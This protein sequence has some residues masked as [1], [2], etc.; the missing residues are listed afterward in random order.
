MLEQLKVWPQYALPQHG[1]S[2]FMGLLAES[3]S[4]PIRKA[5]IQF[6]LTRY[7][8]DL[9]EAEHTDADA[10]PTFNAFFTRALKPNARPLGE[11]LVCPADGAIS[12]L[13]AISGNQIFQAKGQHY[14]TE[15]LL[16]GDQARAA[17]FVNGSFAT[18][19][20][21]PRDY[22]RVHMPLAGKLREMIYVPGDLFSVNALTAR[23][24]PALFG[25]NERVVCLFDTELGPMALVLVG[26]MIVASVETVWHGLVAPHRRAIEVK[27]YE[28][29]TAPTLARGEEM[30]R[31]LLGSTVVMLLPAGSANWESDLRADSG[32]R[33]G[34]TL[35]HLTHPQSTQ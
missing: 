34:Q 20:L 9:S 32:V 23:H 29:A 3:K 28:A 26:A 11:G 12:Q 27:R 5:L 18:I 21:S 10:Y 8:I 2:R 6:F 22:H 15:Q 16:G 1:L 7:G 4:P 25:R 19:Y 35:A 33:M 13:G 14:T 17:A 31:F 24:V 30:G